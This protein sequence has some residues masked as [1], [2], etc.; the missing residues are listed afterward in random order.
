VSGNTVDASALGPSCLQ[1]FPLAGQA[2][3]IPVFNTPPPPSE[4]EDCLFL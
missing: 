3:S 1:Q 2:V 4:N